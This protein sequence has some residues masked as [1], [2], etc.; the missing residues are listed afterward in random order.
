MKN[1]ILILL[2]IL[3]V[4]YLTQKKEKYSMIDSSVYYSSMLN[5]QP[6]ERL[7]W[8]Q[9]GIIDI[10]KLNNKEL[11]DDIDRAQIDGEK[12]L[13]SLDDRQLRDLDNIKD[14]L[15]D[16]VSK[17]KSKGVLTPEKIEKIKRKLDNLRKETRERNLSDIVDSMRNR[18]ERISKLQDNFA[19]LDSSIY[20]SSMLN[21]QPNER[22]SWEQFAAIPT[23]KQMRDMAQK[24]S[25]QFGNIFNRREMVQKNSEQFGNMLDS[26]IYYSN[27]LNSQPNERLAWE[28]FRNSKESEQ[29][30]NM[31]DSSIN[32]SSM[33]NSQPKERLGWEQFGVASSVSST[34]RPPAGGSASNQSPVSNYPSPQSD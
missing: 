15:K 11:Q 3:V 30:G 19:M 24:K 5:S 10:A 13:K 27:M 23:E 33:L 9:F 21:A 22:I 4:I 31:L 2:V 7:S 14:D 6:N 20:Y 29:F 26:S 17:L 34:P 28:Q 16:L 1:L 8:E 12:L 32:Y 18:I 25:E